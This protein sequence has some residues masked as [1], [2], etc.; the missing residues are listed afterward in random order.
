MA[1]KLFLALCST[2]M[3]VSC[4]SCKKDNLAPVDQL[5]PATQEGK[6]TLGCLINGKPFIAQPSIG[7][8]AYL[9]ADYYANGIIGIHSKNLSSNEYKYI[10]I[11][12][13]NYSVKTGTLVDTGSTYHP[14]NSSGNYALRNLS[15]RSFAAN[16]DNGIQNCKYETDSVNKGMLTI[17]KFQPSTSSNPGIISG[18]FYFTVKSPGCADINV[19]DGRFD[20]SF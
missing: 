4:K 20:I 12:Q 1:R 15:L 18:T 7:N 5:P 19:T 13:S 16:Y 17:T 9:Y 6:R 14:I 8:S 2:F 3:L 10:Y 11:Y